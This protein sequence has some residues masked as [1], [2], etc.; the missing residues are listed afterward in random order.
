MTMESFTD[1]QMQVARERISRYRSEAEAA[2]RVP[3]RRQP[4]RQTIGH[5]IIRIGERLAAEPPLQPARFR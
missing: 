2:R 1:M 4:I 3:Q 5:T